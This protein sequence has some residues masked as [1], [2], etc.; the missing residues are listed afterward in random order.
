MRADIPFGKYGPYDRGRGAHRHRGPA[1]GAPAY[2]EV[3]EVVPVTAF[4]FGRGESHSR[5]HWRR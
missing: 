4:G 3:L 2:A 1:Q 5:T